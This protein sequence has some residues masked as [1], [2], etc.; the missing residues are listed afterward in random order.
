MEWSLVRLRN[1]GETSQF[2]LVRCMQEKE[3]VWLEEVMELSD[4]RTLSFLL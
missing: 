4:N 3:R 1:I 2:G